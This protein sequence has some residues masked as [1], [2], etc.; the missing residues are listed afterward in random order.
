[1]WY[2]RYN[3]NGWGSI[4]REMSDLHCR[5]DN[6]FSVKE[7]GEFPSINVYASGETAV[8]TALA[9]GIA[10]DELQLS[11]KD[12]ILT[13]SGSRPSETEKEKSTVLRRERRTGQFSRT[14]QLPFR[15]NSENVEAQFKSGLLSVKL[16]RAESDRPRRIEVKVSNSGGVL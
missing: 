15:V 12:D 4:W 14:I 2:N 5:M 9:P 11:I 7:R 1:M 13:I 6:F 8:V 3:Q 10:P 16:P